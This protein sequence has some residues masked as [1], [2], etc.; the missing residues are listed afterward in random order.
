[1]GVQIEVTVSVGKTRLPLSELIKLEK[2]SVLQLDSRIEDPVDIYVGD[3]LVARGELEELDGDAG[4][5]GVRL[6]EVADLSGGV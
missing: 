6:T 5:L 2:E 4:H 3:K 1:M